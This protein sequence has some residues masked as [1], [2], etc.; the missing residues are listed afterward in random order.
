MAVPARSSDLRL[1]A[2]K[3]GLAVAEGL[4]QCHRQGLDVIVFEAARSDELQRYYYAQGRTRPGKIITN[5]ASAQFGWHFYRLAV[6]VI[7]AKRGWDVTDSWQLAVAEI[8]EKV[9][10]DWGGRWRSPDFPHYQWGRL[11]SSPSDRARQ[12]Y[13]EGGLARVWQE[14]GAA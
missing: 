12:L 7:S 3:F 2:P 14:V 5:A 10:L 9:G 13:A 8:F 11:R 4:N 1:L 6:D